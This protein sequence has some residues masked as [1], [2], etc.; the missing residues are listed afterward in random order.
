[1]D[2][3]DVERFAAALQ[4]Q[5]R[6]ESRL[7]T[8]QE[9][10]PFRGKRSGAQHLAA[11][12]AAK[13]AVGKLLGCGVTAWRDIEVLSDGGAPQVR[14]HGRA[15]HRAKELGI[16][17]VAISLTHTATIAAACALAMAGTTSEQR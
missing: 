15:L 16:G 11:R 6:L 5:P 1:M 13:E 2:V 8:E 10:A 9:A 17:E 14:L 7:F 12:F 4:R 3:V